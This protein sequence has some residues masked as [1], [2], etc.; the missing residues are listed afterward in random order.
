MRAVRI[1]GVLLAALCNAADPAVELEGL[2][3]EA[4]RRIESQYGPRHARA[5][6]AWR[7]LGLFLFE[8]RKPVEAEPFL[9]RALAV[10]LKTAQDEPLIVAADREALA[11]IRLALGD[12]DEAAALYSQAL[13]ARAEVQGEKHP[14]TAEMRV[15]LGMALEATGD[16]AGAVEQYQK[17]V[18]AVPDAAVLERLSGLA[19]AH[20]K[21]DEAER[22]MRRALD[23]YQQELGPLHPKTAVAH[24]SLGMLAMGAGRLDEAA[25]QFES[26]IASYR[27]GPGI[28][29]PDAAFAVDNLG[30]VRREQGRYEESQRL[31]ERALAIRRATVGEGHPDTATTLVNLGGLFHVQGKLAEAEPLYREALAIQLEQS[32]GNDPAAGETL[33]NLGHLLAAQG[34]RKGAIEAFQQAATILER[35]YGAGDELVVEIRG[36]LAQLAPR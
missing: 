11:A 29:R 18:A 31:L 28:E 25:A 12:G 1:L 20:G 2:F 33:Y 35:A 9:R 24:N 7:D 22:H 6:D 23:L 21:L 8:H 32:E 13:E 19:E 5:A 26:A 15:R 36:L 27:D 30:N 10:H 4:A 14:D 3:R 34:D 16:E 17:S